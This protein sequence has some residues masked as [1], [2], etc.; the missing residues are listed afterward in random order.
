M[1]ATPVLQRQRIHILQAAALATVPLLLVAQPTWGGAAHEFIEI[2]GVCLVF[3][4]MVGRMWSTL[5]VGSKKNHEL[6]TAGPY[7]ITRNPLYFFST[8]GAVGIGLMYGSV[9]VSLVLGL[10]T[11]A[12][13]ITTA[14]KEAA[15]LATV[16]GAEHDRYAQQ[17]PMFWPDL[18]LYREASETYFSP[19]AL[20]RTLLDGLLFLAAFPIIETIEYLQVGGYLPI[21]MR[22]L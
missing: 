8:I 13:L 21:L 2:V 5:Y 17:T 4:C 22:L 20:K 16:F 12:V 9:I 18:S 11:Y 1:K 6:V 19:K 3:A 15:Y 10:V 7:S 14:S